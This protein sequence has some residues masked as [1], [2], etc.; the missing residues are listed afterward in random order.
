MDDAEQEPDI[1][2]TKLVFVR[3]YV[4][5]AAAAEE[6]GVPSTPDAIATAQSEAVRSSPGHD[7]L[8]M[9]PSSHRAFGP[10]AAGFLGSSAVIPKAAMT[11][12]SAARHPR[13]PSLHYGAMSAYC[14]LDWYLRCTFGH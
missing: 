5:A 13:I 2:G 10:V 1:G 4:A 8:P 12:A 14:K 9:R 6:V 11:A 7:L 3:R